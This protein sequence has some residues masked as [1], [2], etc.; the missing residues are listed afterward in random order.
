M[1]NYPKL[2]KSYPKLS[3]SYLKVIQKLSKWAFNNSVKIHVK[4][5]IDFHNHYFK[6]NLI[7]DINKLKI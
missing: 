1:K 5:N 4:F 3:K 6:I 2:S 7:P